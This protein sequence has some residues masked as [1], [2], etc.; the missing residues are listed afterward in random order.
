MKIAL[1]IFIGIAL[2]VA[3]VVVLFANMNPVFGN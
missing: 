3:A 2:C 1:G